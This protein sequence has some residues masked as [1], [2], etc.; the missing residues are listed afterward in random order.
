MLQNILERLVFLNDFFEILFW[1]IWDKL[2]RKS[3]KVL[4]RNSGGKRQKL[5]SKEFSKLNPSPTM[6]DSRN[7]AVVSQSSVREVDLAR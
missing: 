1:F 4:A 5:Q 7:N 6:S 3:K 2:R